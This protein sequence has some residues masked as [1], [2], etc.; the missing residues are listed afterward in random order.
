MKA[1]IPSSIFLNAYFTDVIGLA[2][3][4]LPDFKIYPNPSNGR[5]QIDVSD[6]DPGA[7]MGI[8]D[9]SGRII[10]Q[11][12]IRTSTLMEVQIEGASPGMYLM[13]IQSPEGKR[14]KKITIQ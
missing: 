9:L 4:T 2:E 5:F 6:I 7:F 11:E 12:R 10:H 13:E 14:T 3:N 1:P 8:Y